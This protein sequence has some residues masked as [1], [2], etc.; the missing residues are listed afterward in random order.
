MRALVNEMLDA[1]GPGHRIVW[2][3][4][5]N[6]FNTLPATTFNG[7]LAE[8]SAERNDFVVA[9]WAAQASHP[10]YLVADQVHLTGAGQ[11]AFAHAIAEAADRAALLP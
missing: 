2:V 11:L 8:V 9:E 10:G 7:V 6:G 1:I 5:H 4:I 3:N